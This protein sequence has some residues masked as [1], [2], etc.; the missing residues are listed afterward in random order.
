[1]IMLLGV[2]LM[3]DLK[4]FE[5]KEGGSKTAMAMFVDKRQNMM[6]RSQQPCSRRI[7]VEN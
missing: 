5:V 6:V 2:Y 3:S 1:M 4:F 7:I